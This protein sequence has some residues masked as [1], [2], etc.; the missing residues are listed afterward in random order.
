MT[1][2]SLPWLVIALS[3]AHCLTAQTPPQAKASIQ[4]PRSLTVITGT[5]RILNDGTFSA[6]WGS[7][8]LPALAFT[9]GP[10]AA[11]ADAMHANKADFTRSDRHPRR[12]TQRNLRIE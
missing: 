5:C 3:I 8:T 10:H 1:S 12:P 9:I 4:K 11:M 2:N 7:T 6:N